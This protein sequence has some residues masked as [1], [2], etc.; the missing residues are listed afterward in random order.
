[1][2]AQ[3]TNHRMPQTEKKRTKNKEKH[4]PAYF[5]FVLWILPNTS[6]IRNLSCETVKVIKIHK[7]QER[8]VVDFFLCN[9]DLMKTGAFKV[10]EKKWNVIRTFSCHILSLSLTT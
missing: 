6:S 5:S 9:L 4:F 1:M 10:S 2:D 3:D 8:A 7:K